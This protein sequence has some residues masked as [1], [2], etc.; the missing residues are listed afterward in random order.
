[1]ILKKKNVLVDLLIV[2]FS[3][4]ILVKT[5]FTKD[6]SLIKQISLKETGDIEE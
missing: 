5:I 6:Q 1:M 4:K 3:Y 2:V